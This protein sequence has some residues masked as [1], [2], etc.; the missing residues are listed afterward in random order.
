MFS[1]KNW[2][3]KL[4]IITQDLVCSFVFRQSLSSDHVLSRDRFLS[5][6]FLF[7]R[8][9]RVHLLSGIPVR[10]SHIHPHPQHHKSTLHVASSTHLGRSSYS[11]KCSAKVIDNWS[12]S[13]GGNRGPIV[14]KVVWCEDEG[15]DDGEAEPRTCCVL[16]PQ[17][18]IRWHKP[19]LGAT[20]N[21]NLR[22]TTVERETV[23]GQL[24]ME[25]FLE[26]VTQGSC[27]EREKRVSKHPKPTFF[28]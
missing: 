23:G 28:V 27:E 20:S 13:T 5:K 12:S 24:R 9:P 26:E 7:F 21:N 22:T 18:G 6:T 4:C 2:K 19:G 8:P 14:E 10:P 16:G 11:V 3:E 15:Q 1:S 17:D 25:K